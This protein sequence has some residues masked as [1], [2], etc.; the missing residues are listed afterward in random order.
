MRIYPS[1]AS[2]N[3]LYLHKSIQEIEQ[4]NLD[5][6]HVDIEDGNFVPVM[7]LG[8][9]IISSIRSGTKLQIG[10]HLMVSNPDDLIATVI[11]NG[12]DSVSFHWETSKYPRKTLGLIKSFGKKAGIA[13]NPKTNL[14][15]LSPYLDLLDFVLILSSEPDQIGDAFLPSVLTKIKV[16]KE[17]Y[18]NHDLEWIVDGGINL[19]NIRLLSDFEVDSV[20]IGR[21]VFEN[22]TIMDNVRKLR[23]L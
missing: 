7:R 23:Q 11:Q 16:G 18:G 6:I 1:I 5:G 15:D 12:A 10:V 17:Y 14:P 13:L 20:V 8:T 9:E 19:N 2:A 4:A 21:G 3:L 22:N